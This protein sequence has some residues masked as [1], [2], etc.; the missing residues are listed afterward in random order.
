MPDAITY[1]QDCRTSTLNFNHVT[2]GGGD[3]KTER[4]S[5]TF[6]VVGTK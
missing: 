4:K 1:G 5:M 6:L 3:Y 2:N